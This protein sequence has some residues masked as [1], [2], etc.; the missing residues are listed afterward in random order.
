MLE[1]GPPAERGGLGSVV[2][3]ARIEG[4]E[5][6]AAALFISAPW[7]LVNIGNRAVSEWPTVMRVDIRSDTKWAV[8]QETETSTRYCGFCENKLCWR[9]LMDGEICEPR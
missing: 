5:F 1:I 7:A 4:A 6:C 3:P 9:I 8:R 2:R